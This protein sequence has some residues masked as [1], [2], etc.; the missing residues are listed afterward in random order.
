MTGLGTKILASAARP[1]ERSTGLQLWPSARRSR[2]KV[3]PIHVNRR[4]WASHA[5]ADAASITDRGSRVTL[6]YLA[7]HMGSDMM[8]VVL[9][10]T[11][12]AGFAERHHSM[13]A[14]LDCG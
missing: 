10:S 9:R 1:S 2:K 13:H 14:S 5:T 7:L 3:G 6:A 4:F 12:S 11:Q 8:P